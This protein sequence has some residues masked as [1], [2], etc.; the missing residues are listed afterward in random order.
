MLSC[1]GMFCLFTASSNVFLR[2]RVAV[3]SPSKNLL[4]VA[5]ACL[6]SFP[7]ALGRKSRVCGDEVSKT[8]RLLS[9]F[10][11]SQCYRKREEKELPSSPPPA[12]CTR[13]H[14]MKLPK[15]RRSLVERNAGSLQGCHL[16]AALCQTHAEKTR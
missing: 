8:C 5:I 14:E 4:R 2:L 13:R 7:E 16:R 10:V 6:L 12:L 1:T 11:L 9:V 15:P 3:P